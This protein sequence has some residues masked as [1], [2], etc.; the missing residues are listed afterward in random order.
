MSK[1]NKPFKLNRLTMAVMLATATI[2]QFASAGAGWGDS[3]N[4]ANPNGKIQTF[5]ASSPSG[6]FQAGACFDAAG[7][8]AVPAAGGLC[9]SGGYIDPTT[10]IL[11][12]GDT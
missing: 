8:A 3:T 9:D 11:Q 6:L 4:P 2:P 12:R 1:K 5:Y 7:N 10:G